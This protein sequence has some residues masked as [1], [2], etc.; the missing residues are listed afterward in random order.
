MQHKF[1]RHSEHGVLIMFFLIL[2]PVYIIFALLSHVPSLVVIETQGHIAG[3]SLT[4][5]D[6]RPAFLYRQKGSARSSL[7]DS[8]RVTPTDARLSRQ[9]YRWLIRKE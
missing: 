6:T 2:H 3:S 5:Y 9:P 7:G 1:A 8:C 4:H